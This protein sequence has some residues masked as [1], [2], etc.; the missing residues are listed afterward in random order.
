MSKQYV[1][2]KNVGDSA[3][4]IVVR[5][6]PGTGKY[7]DVEFED[8][9]GNV[10]PVPKSAADRQLERLGLTDDG[11]VGRIITI[12]RSE[13]RQDA[14][15]PYWNIEANGA[16]KAK[17]TGGVPNGAASGGGQPANTRQSTSESHTPGTAQASAS[18]KPSALYEKVTDFV[19]DKIVPRYEAAGI[20]VTDR[21]VAAMVATVY[22][23]ARDN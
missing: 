15:K 11:I 20:P 2:L 12:S 14:S 19:L 6:A 17:G 18:E 1:K 22:I 5:C 8:D 3:T 16:A 13:N 10:Y 9:K 23:A 4:F 7:P 21:G